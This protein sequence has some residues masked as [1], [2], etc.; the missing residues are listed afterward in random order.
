MYRRSALV[1]ALPL[2]WACAPAQTTGPEQAPPRLPPS[3]APTG[4]LP[5]GHYDLMA[6]VVH[7]SCGQS[8]T[9]P[10]RVTLLKHHDDGAP[11]AS[12][13]IQR[14]GDFDEKARRI[15]IDLRGYQASGMT[16]P[17]RCPGLQNTYRAELEN[18]TDTSF[19]MHVEFA[20]ADGWDCPNPR[21]APLCETRIVYQY[22]L[23]GAAC[24]AHC[25]GTVP[26]VPNKDV[27]DGPVALSC[28]C[29]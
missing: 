6:R 4:P 10:Q 7:D 15:D 21:P 3:V 16:H 9:L 13:P 12:I 18:V 11:R 23:A 5:A 8:R 27:P 1:L 17:K 2:V 28:A 29:P 26:G 22:R 19:E 14:F 25:D 20:V 24:A